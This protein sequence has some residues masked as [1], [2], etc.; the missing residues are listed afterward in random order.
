MRHAFHT[1]G[2]GLRSQEWVSIGENLSPCGSSSTAIVYFESISSEGGILTTSQR[3]PKIQLV[4]KDDISAIVTCNV[5]LK[6]SKRASLTKTGQVL[7]EKWQ[8]THGPYAGGP[9]HCSDTHTI[10]IGL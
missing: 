9:H 4:Q 2:N 8:M 10:L 1:E 3:S 5:S 7:A 6:M